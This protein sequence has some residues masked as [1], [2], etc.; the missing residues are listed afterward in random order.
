M[1]RYDAPEP[2]TGS[3]VE[4]S[5]AWSVGQRNRFWNVKGDE[6]LE[7]LRAKVTEVHLA[8]VEGEAIVVAD[9]LTDADLER[10]DVRLY[11][12]FRGTWIACLID[13][14]KLGEALRRALFATYE[15]QNSAMTTPGE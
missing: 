11:E 2:F 13:V 7:L 8:A 10:L 9:A 5:D 1:P 15:E 6:F 12:W 14:G 3:Y 4:Y